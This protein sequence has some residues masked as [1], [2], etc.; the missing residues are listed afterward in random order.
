MKKIYLS[1][2]LGKGKFAI[3]DDEDYETINKNKWNLSF[4]GYAQRIVYIGTLN[5]KK[6]RKSEK[7]HRV[8]NKTP[9]EMD[10]DHINRDKLDNRKKNLRICT[11]NENLHNQK[12][13]G[14][15][16]FKGVYKKKNRWQSAIYS[17]YMRIFLGSFKTKEEAALAYNEA[18]KKYHGEFAV[19]NVVSL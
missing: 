12:R 5:G 6:I 3:V 11:H 4:N 1:G 13:S 9:I 15:S 7:M 17:N 16:E 19:L 2:V 10:T 14:S 18:A 8:L